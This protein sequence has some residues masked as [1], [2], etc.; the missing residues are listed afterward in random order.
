MSQM[1]D[2][3]LGYAVDQQRAGKELQE[4]EVEVEQE[5]AEEDEEEGE[6]EP[7]QWQGWRRR[8]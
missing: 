2:F 4:A 6:G 5:A 1:R 3:Q 8:R 7:W